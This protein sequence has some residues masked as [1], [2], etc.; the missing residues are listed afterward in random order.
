MPIHSRWTVPLDNCSFQQYIFGPPSSTLSDKVAFYDAERPD[1]H[2]L[3]LQTFRLWSQRLAA[4]LQKTGL[5]PGDRVLLF[6][7]NSLYFPVAFMGIVMAGG[8]FTGANP[9]FVARELAYQLK[10]SGSKFLLCADSS[11]DLSVEAA[12]SI[13]MSKDHIFIFD[14]LLL[15]G[16]GSPKLG[17][18]NW[19]FLMESGEV[20][21]RFRWYEPNDPKD[22]IC[23]LNYSSGTTGVPKGVMITHYNYVANATQFAHLSQLD[24]DEPQKTKQAKWLCFLPM[25]HAMAQTIFI[26]G[27]PKRGIPVY[28]MK[29]FDFV[30]VLE[31]IQKY[32]ITVLSM[33]PPIVVAL[34]K[35]PLTKKYDLSSIEHIGSGAAPLGGDVIKEAEALWPSGDRKL[36]Q[37]WGMTEATCSL[38]G[39]DPRLE[40]LPDSV[41]EL[42]ANCHAKIVDLEGNEVATCERG[43]IWVQAPNIMKGYWRNQKATD[44]VFVDD[45]SGRWMRTGDVAYVDEKGRFF[46]VDRIKELIKVK[47]NQ[48]A[49]AELEALLLEHPQL[50]DAAVIGVTISGEEVPRAYVVAQA[51]EK[52]N[53]SE[54]EVKEWLAK[55]VSRYK[56]LEGG[57]VFVD[58]VPKNP[59]SFDNSQR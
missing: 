32:S 21:E 26:A 27:G 3:T 9:S 56:R 30:Q 55:R 8:I 31:A 15:E 18:K 25:Y 5:K 22:W 57:V 7:G 35:S 19:A 6:S 12:E 33:V 44:E 11:L 42:N 51:S 49:P 50:A 17:I 39:W 23:C 36:K 4:G 1:T 28:I 24:P 20:G 2:H 45:E 14:D 13:G 16:T 40:S 29:K 54:A 52:G 46:I 34:A 41:G 37:G 38:L 10:D 58:V 53:V 47:G 48:V 43:E 59:V